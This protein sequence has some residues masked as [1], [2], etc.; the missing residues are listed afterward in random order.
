ME[1]QKVAKKIELQEEFTY[2]FA[3]FFERFHNPSQ[4]WQSNNLMCC[5]WLRL[6]VL[7]TAMRFCQPFES[8][9]M[10]LNYSFDDGG[11]YRIAIRKA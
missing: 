4:S 3:L 10:T 5:M 6:T 11:K 2:Y 7:T 9:Y 8:P 1:L